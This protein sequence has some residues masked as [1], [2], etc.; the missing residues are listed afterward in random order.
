VG[1]AEDVTFPRRVQLAVIAHIRHVHTDYEKL[2]KKLPRPVARLQIEPTCLRTLLKW[3]GED[4]EVEIEERTEEVIVIDES[5]SEDELDYYSPA[6]PGPKDPS[7]LE[8][9]SWK[10]GGADFQGVQNTHALPQRNRPR[11]NRTRSA[12]M[13]SATSFRGPEVHLGSPITGPGRHVPAQPHTYSSVI[14]HTQNRTII[15]LTEDPGYT[16]SFA[17][18]FQVVGD[19]DPHGQPVR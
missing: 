17:G 15:D 14:P 8:I 9:V 3:R 6:S 12:Q 2:L 4:D 10:R 1:N 7:E 11:H 13:P 16:P 5:E 19:P 18:P